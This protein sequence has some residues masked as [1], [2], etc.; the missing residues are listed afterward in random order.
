MLTTATRLVLAMTLLTGLVFGLAPELDLVVAKAF[1]REGGG[2]IGV[3]PLGEMLRSIFYVAPFWILGLT[4]LGWI[5]RRLGLPWLWLPSGRAVLFMAAT[6]AVGPGLLVNEGL[7]DNSH[8]PR[9]VQTLEFG[10]KWEFRPWY[11]FDGQCARNCSFVSGEAASAF[12]TVAP[13]MLTPPPIRPL[14]IATALTFGVATSALRIAFGGHYLSDVLLA[15]LFTLLIVLALYRFLMRPP[16]KESDL[17]D[18][19]AAL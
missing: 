16:T 8:R 1:W 10:G 19:D 4:A 9:P 13:A 15:G 14:A 6:L 3:T 11:R 5:L 18:T 2:F 12:W 17:R 7:K